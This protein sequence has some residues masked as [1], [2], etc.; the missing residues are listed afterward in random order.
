M[1]SV[2]FFL[3]KYTL[4][5]QINSIVWLSDCCRVMILKVRAVDSMPPRR[6]TASC[7]TFSQYGPSSRCFSHYRV[8]V[9]LQPISGCSGLRAAAA[10]LEYV[11]TLRVIMTKN[12]CT[13]SAICSLCAR[14]MFFFFFFLHIIK[15]PSFTLKAWL[16]SHYAHK[17][18]SLR[19]I[20]SK[21]LVKIFKMPS[22]REETCPWN[23]NLEERR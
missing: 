18:I 9:S 19:Q 3:R 16:V 8:T 11:N 13:M 4:A 23:L 1:C 12:P 5:I 10:W 2:I 21:Y 15:A 7:K 14:K 6:A 17:Q 22:M 20:R